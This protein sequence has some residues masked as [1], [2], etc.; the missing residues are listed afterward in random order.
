[1]SEMRIHPGN[2]FFSRD[3]KNDLSKEKLEK[4]NFVNLNFASFSQTQEYEYIMKENKISIHVEI[5]R[6]FL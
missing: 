6:C 2:N 1:M 3:G 4:V 5:G